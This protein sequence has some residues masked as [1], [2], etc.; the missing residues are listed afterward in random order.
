MKIYWLLSEKIITFEWMNRMRR[1][2]TNWQK[3]LKFAVYDPKN[4]NEIFGFTTSKIRLF[5]LVLLVFIITVVLVFFVLSRTSFGKN[6]I[7]AGTSPEEAEIIDQR[8]RI[9]SL[10]GQVKAQDAYIANLR[11][12]LFGDFKADSVASEK[13]EVKINPNSIN[14]N[15]SKA[16][17][18]VGENVKADQYTN[19]AKTPTD[20]VHFI[21]PVKGKI[22][23]RFNAKNHQAIDI[24]TPP[25]TYFAACLSGTVIY[26]GFSQKDGNILIIEHPNNYLSIYKHAR[27]TLKKAG[28]KVRV[29]DVI[30]IVGNT[31]ANTSGPHLHFELWLNQ[32]AV[33]PMKYMQFE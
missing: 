15:P 9:D 19:S 3:Q 32:Q 5:S 17:L 4:F 30:G 20:F 8:V 28:E 25:D 18:Q 29:G 26:S 23:Q 24:V 10:A 21:V 13:P 16:E 7:T 33:D 22:S 12:L 6:V 31:G 2:L 11:R 1:W 27:T 14:A